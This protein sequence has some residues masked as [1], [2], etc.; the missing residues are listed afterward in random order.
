MEILALQGVK[1]VCGLVTSPNPNSERLHESLGFTRAG[2]W[3]N[4]GYKQGA[5]RDVALFEK[6]IGAHVDSPA[7][8]VRVGE[9]PEEE[10]G[11]ILDRYGSTI[12]R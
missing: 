6:S 7:P 5:W 12:K 3:H 8:V 2:T 9:L 4:T 10:I 1:N 11:R